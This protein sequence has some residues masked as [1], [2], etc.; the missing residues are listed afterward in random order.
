M[1]ITEQRLWKYIA[2]IWI[3]LV[4]SKL[5]TVMQFF[6]T[7]CGGMK[8][9]IQHKAIQ[10][11]PAETDSANNSLSS[12]ATQNR[13]Q[14]NFWNRQ[15]TL[16]YL[17]ILDI[18]EAPAIHY[19]IGMQTDRWFKSYLELV[20]LSYHHHHSVNGP[21][22]LSI[23]MVQFCMIYNLYTKLAYENQWLRKTEPSDNR[24]ESSPLTEFFNICSVSEVAPAEPSEL[25]TCCRGGYM[26]WLLLAWL[27]MMASLFLWFVS[28]WALLN[29]II[30]SMNSVKV[31]YNQNIIM[32]RCDRT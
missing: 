29:M 14:K 19:A 27:A 13:K 26:Y 3:R 11:A 25:P 9:R 18:H 2:D 21:E 6:S 30:L 8:K 15:G 32:L 28:K 1:E 17:A 20:S 24:W 31:I 22:I 4:I 7:K 5:I 16:E 23:T 10:R 12:T